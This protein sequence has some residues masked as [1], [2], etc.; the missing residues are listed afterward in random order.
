MEDTMTCRIDVLDGGVVLVSHNP[1]SV[2]TTTAEQIKTIKRKPDGHY[3]RAD[4]VDLVKKG[5]AVQYDEHAV[6]AIARA[7][8]FLIHG[9]PTF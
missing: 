7:A 9:C 2:I 5:H 1:I 8:E 6:R 3:D 4:V